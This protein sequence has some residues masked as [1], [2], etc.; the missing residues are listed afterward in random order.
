MRALGDTSCD[1][2]ASQQNPINSGHNGI[3]MTIGRVTLAVY[4]FHCGKQDSIWPA[5]RQSK[6]E[7]ARKR[8]KQTPQSERHDAPARGGVGTAPQAGRV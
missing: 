7:Q 8:T 6:A 3:A 4:A 5:A 1:S 2:A